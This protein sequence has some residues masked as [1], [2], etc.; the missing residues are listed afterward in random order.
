MAEEEESQ[1]TQLAA[2]LLDE[3]D[4][5]AAPEAEGRSSVLGVAV[6]LGNA[7][8]GGGIVGLPAALKDSGLGLGCL[9]LLGTALAVHLV[10]G[11]LVSDAE[12]LNEASYG[13]LARRALGPAGEVLVC[14]G[15]FVFDVGSALTYLIIFGDTAVSS[16]EFFVAKPP[17]YLRLVCVAG[18]GIVALPPCLLRDVSGLEG[19]S[20]LSVA[21]VFAATGVVMS[22][23][24]TRGREGSLQILA[25]EKEGRGVVAALG[26]FAFAFVCQDSCFLYYRSLKRRTPQRFGRATGLALGASAVLCTLFAAAGYLT[27]GAQT[28]SNILNDYPVHDIRAL[29]ARFLYAV[30][31]LCG[32]PSSVFVCRQAGHALHRAA[33]VTYAESS[34]EDVRLVAPFTHG[35]WSL[36]LW[37]GLVSVALATDSLGAVMALTGAVAGSLIGFILPGL[38]FSSPVVLGACEKPFVLRRRIASVG[39]VAFGATLVCLSFAAVS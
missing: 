17:A 19:I 16:V 27:Y 4:A 38:I 30:I 7:I 20:I 18:A 12:V 33:S 13:G 37:A 11:G 36:S 14:G 9:L 1:T 23:L 6:N 35:A 22:E 24:Y 34:V 31:S 8:V 10:V 39:L 32:I 5:D 21:A 26:L 25:P 2:P 28:S 3:E 15:Q 29:I